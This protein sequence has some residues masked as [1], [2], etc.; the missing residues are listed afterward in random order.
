MSSAWSSMSCVWVLSVLWLCVSHLVPFSVFLLFHSSS[1]LTLSWTF[2]SIWSSSGRFSAGTPPNEESGP[3]AENTSFHKLWAQHPWRL[4][5]LRDQ[6]NLPPRAFQR[7]DGLV[8]G[9]ELRDHRQSTLFT[10]IHSVARKTSR[11][12]TSL[13][14]KV[15][16]QLSPCQCVVQ[17]RGDP[18]MNSV[19]KSRNR[20][21]QVATQKM[22]ESIFSLNDK[23]QIF[24]DCRA[25]IQ[26]HDVQTDSDR[27]SMRDLS[28][29]IVSQ[30]GEINRA[31]AGD[32]NFDEINNFFMKKKIENFL[33]LIWEVSLRW[34]NWSDFRV[35]HSTQL[36]K[37]DCDDRDTSLELTIKIQ[38]LLNEMNCLSGLTDA[39]SV[40][41]GHS[42]V[43][44]QP[45]SFPPHPILGGMPSRSIGMPSRLKGRQAFL[46]HMVY[47]ETFASPDASSTAPYPQELNPWS[48][49]I[50]EPIHST[51]TEKNENQTP[52]QDQRCQSGPSAKDSVIPSGR[53]S[54][55][56]YE[57]DQQRLQISDLHFDKFPTPATFACWKIRFKI[58]VCTCSQLPKEALHWI[59]EVE[60]VDS[61]D[62]LKTS[63]SIR[64]ISMSNFEVLDG[65]IASE[66]NRIINNS[67]F[68]RRVILEVQK[69]RKRNVSVVDHKSITW[70]TSTSLPLEPT[71]LSRIMPKYI[72][73]GF[74]NDD[75][76]EFDSK[77]DGIL[78]YDENPTWWYLGR[79]VQMKNTRVWQAQDRIGIVRPGDSSKEVRTWLSQIESYGEEKYRTKNSK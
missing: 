67:H 44:N 55:K 73:T 35:L 13:L 21:N 46:T 10:T 6:L 32:G 27:R 63:S 56:D 52:V 41:N 51:T 29:I 20:Q 78:V 38:E 23:E 40:R 62:E 48:S 64:G 77:W 8:R 53:D 11:R 75:I 58:E 71:I 45:V 60:M 1:T 24:A 57:A 22:S 36:Q 37:E 39:E 65:K 31:L 66:L 68:K 30:R 19:R 28:G 9:N 4:S 12:K 25:E 74:R 18:C 2:S 72:T 76:Q 54:L 49:R 14:K 59:K 15:C 26:K 61:V 16:C 33:K 69:S 17:E 43:T 70:S 3:L 7:H 34:K 47:R 50:S 42:H 5:R 79:I